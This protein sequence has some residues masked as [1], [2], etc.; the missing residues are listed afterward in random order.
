MEVEMEKT[1]GEIKRL[2]A[3]INDLISVLAL[4]AIWS[5]HEPSQIVSTLLDVLLGMLRLDFAYARLSDSIGGGAPIE[6]VRLAHSRN[7]TAQPQEIGEALNR[8][9]T[10]APPTSA[11]VVP[12]PV[13][14][15]DVSIA[16]FRLGLQDE[17]GVLVAGSQRADFPTETERLLLRVAANQAAIGLQEARLLSEQ[18]LAAEELEQRV[19]DRT[20]Q[21]TAVNEELRKEIIERNRAEEALR[22]SEERWRAVFENS[23]AGIALANFSGR[24]LAANSAY[25][26]M[27][28]YSDEEL[29]ELSFL[30][31]THEDYRD[32]NSQLDT[33]L[34]EGSRQYF[35][36]EKRYR[37]KD[38]TL[39]W[40]RVHVSLV[41]GTESI[42]RFFLAIVEDITERKRAEKQFRALLESAPDAHVIVNETGTIVLANSQTEKLFGYARHELLGQSIEMLVPER[43][44]HKHSSHRAGFFANA[45]ARSMGTGR[46]LYAIRKDGSEF[47]TEISLNPLETDQGVLVTAAVRDITERKRADAE[48]RESERRYRYFFQSA[49][50]SILEEDFSQVKIAIDDLKARG[51]QD[52]RQYLAAHPEFVEQGIRMVKILDVN[53]ATVELFGAQDKQELLASSDKIFKTETGQV[54]AGVL[55]LLEG[56][57]R[58]ESQMSLKTLKGDPISVAFTITF[59]AEPAKLNSVLVS[60]MDITEQKR[61]EEAL[62]KAQAE[63]AHVTRVTT[64][65]ELAASIA[66]E[67]NQPLAAVV[68]NGNAC[69]RWLA[70]TTPNLNEAREAVWR[71]IRDGNRASAVITRIRALVRKT[72]TE[73][74]RLDINQIVQEVVFLTQN[75]AVRKGVTLQMELAADVPSVLGDRVQLQQVILNLVMNGV[76]AMVSVA[77][78]PRELCIRARRHESDQVLVAVQDSGIGIDSQNLEK[79]FDAFYTTKP[80]GMGMGLAIS[81]SIVEN[82]GG[83]LWAI[84]NDGP[85][86]TFQFTLEVGTEEERRL[87]L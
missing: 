51:V 70:G 59:P 50:V 30:D 60:I 24:F 19:A 13:G 7:L 40:A 56:R 35:E 71:I 22:K 45:Q 14:E 55:T 46:E 21:A 8:W 54:L 86:A 3:C 33:E 75:E 41:P 17:V 81:R 31:I 64:M 47:P 62:H 9:L 73:K 66:H 82:H 28:G 63:L 69:L 36:M 37:R 16:P 38:G 10:G 83:R 79:I 1:A 27:V 53:Q 77:D 32:A 61:A 65:G 18:R 34:L 11:F 48:L 23:A 43:F 85:G 67:V 80:Q 29:R 4:P 76:E 25:Q 2:K 87:I 58:F 72:D 74:G 84:P 12:N 6:M 52:F 68:T 44:R 57:S 15:G 39:I 78:R 42:P 5:G 49:G 20:R 26:K